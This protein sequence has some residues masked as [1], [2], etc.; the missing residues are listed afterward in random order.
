MY[1]L[2]AHILPG[3]DDG[4]KTISESLDMARVA[5]KHGTRHI[6]ATPHRKDVTENWSI[7]HID[8]LIKSLNKEIKADGLDL[9]VYRGMENHLD[10]SLPED[11]TNGR[12]LSINNS[13]YILIELP[14]F[15]M[16]TYVEEVLRQV[17]A[18][19]FIPVL[20][21]PERIEMF[22]TNL[23]LLASF[24]N[25]G[26]L[27]QITAGSIVG[28]FGSEVKSLTLE[29]LRRGLADIIASDTHSP[30]GPRSPNLIDGLKRAE[31]FI[32]MKVASNMVTSN[33]KTIFENQSFKVDN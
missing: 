30:T 22:Q 33:P 20:A 17:K 12:A 31:D 9:T 4:A 18:K 8:I 1:D 6:L 3:V 13:K 5:Y 32:G 15:G 26:M 24:T 21:H 19:D 16:P 27:T 11:I 7:E 28:T 10:I 25:L 29:I 23:E 14:F 2:H